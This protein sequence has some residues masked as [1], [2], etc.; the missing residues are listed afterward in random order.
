MAT[1][2]PGRRP[3]TR[4]DGPAHATSEEEHTGTR[5]RILDIAQDL[6]IENGFDK[7][8]LREI[9][10]RIGFSKA[11]LYYHFASKDDILAALHLRLHQVGRDALGMLEHQRATPQLWASLLESFIGE[12]L[13]HRKLFVMHERNRAALEHLHA[14]GHDQDHG[15]LEQ[16]LRRVLADPTIPFA[17]RVR[18]GCSVGA[19]MSGLLMAGDIFKDAPTGKLQGALQEVV[20]DMMARPSTPRRGRSRERPTRERRPQAR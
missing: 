14:E 1:R 5:E 19:I 12:M 17:D 18:M 13:T 10:E 3:T 4:T 9:A 7:T 8:S 20:H 15:D 2:S 11:A 16:Q 6:F